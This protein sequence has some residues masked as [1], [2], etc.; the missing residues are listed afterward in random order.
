MHSITKLVGSVCWASRIEAEAPENATFLC[1]CLYKYGPM[2][3]QENL[4]D[5]YI[6]TDS[7]ARRD[8]Q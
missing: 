3:F 5:K 2:P 1:L 8:P 7:N 4:V 6:Q